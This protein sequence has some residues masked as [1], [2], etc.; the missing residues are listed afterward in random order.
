MPIRNVNLTEELDRF[1]VSKVESGR[2][3]NAS[4]VVRAGL[5]ALDMQEREDLW[6]MPPTGRTDAFGRYVMRAI[7]VALWIVLGLYGQTPAPNVKIWQDPGDIASRNLLLGPGGEKHQPKGATFKFVK[8][9]LHGT[10]P[11]FDVT[12]DGGR[13]W[14]LKLGNEAQAETAASR[15]L[16]AVGYPTDEYYLVPEAR[17]NE[18]PLRLRRGQNWIGTDGVIHN[19][20]LK[21]APEGFKK[22]GEWEWKQNPFVGTREFNGLRVMMALINNWDL[23]DVNNRIYDSDSQRLYIVSDLGGSLGPTHVVPYHNS[24]SDNLASFEKSPFV[25]GASGDYVD[26]ATPGAAAKVVLFAPNVYAYRESLKW[27][28]DHVPRADARWIGEL[29]F[30]LTPQQIRDAFTSGG[31]SPS[32]T[33]RYAAVIAA[34]IRELNAL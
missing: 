9:D 2:Y 33:E 7:P 29:L 19:A 8:E 13:K 6:A 10:S 26:F 5:R 18:L 21:H 30:H 20:R 28:G 12:D 15:L 11:K 17:L 4:E 32:E 34:R 16:W 14:T 31:Y 27:I 1:V 25:T 3:E 23:K 22:V 24:R